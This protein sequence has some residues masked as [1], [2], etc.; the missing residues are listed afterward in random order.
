M[1][2][3]GAFGRYGGSFMDGA[4]Q[5]L[6]GSAMEAVIGEVKEF[7]SSHPEMLASIAHT[8]DAVTG[9]C[10]AATIK[11][12]IVFLAANAV[13]LPIGGALLVIMVGG[14]VILRIRRR[15]QPQTVIP[16]L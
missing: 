14:V 3:I 13:P 7:L 10:V 12:I 4:S 1:S 2:A 9:V 6:G 5:A 11:G 15:S 8:I 16:A